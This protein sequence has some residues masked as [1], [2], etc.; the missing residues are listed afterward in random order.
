M[1][2]EIFQ[3]LRSFRSS[4]KL[5]KTVLQILVKLISRKELGEL[6]K[7][8]E[9]IDVSKSGVI[10]RAELMQAITDAKFEISEQEL[11]DMIQ[12]V[13]VNDTGQIEYTEFLAATI[14]V[15]K[16]LTKEKTLALF[17]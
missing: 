7:A 2:S 3:A 15:S 8:F 16:Y 6:S 9:E 17:R 13:E 5:H 11:T 12:M 14:D 1:S 4:S 10:S